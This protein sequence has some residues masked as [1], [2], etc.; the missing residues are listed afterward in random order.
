MVMWGII[1]RIFHTEWFERQIVIAKKTKKVKA[2]LVQKLKGV[3][4][5]GIKFLE[6]VQSRLRR[7]I[8]YAKDEL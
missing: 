4:D 5:Y 8:C 7:V 3:Y 6:L 2:T 1:T